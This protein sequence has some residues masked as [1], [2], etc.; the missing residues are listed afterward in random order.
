MNEVLS[1][2][3]GKKITIDNVQLTVSILKDA[4]TPCIFHRCCMISNY[5]NS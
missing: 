1:R 5:N 3:F 2:G 4:T